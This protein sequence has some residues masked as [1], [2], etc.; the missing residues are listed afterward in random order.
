VSKD[1]KLIRGQVRQIVK[2]ILPAVL[3]DELLQAISKQLVANL[4][5]KLT[6]IEE[7]VKETLQAV[8]QRSKDS[9]SY[10]VRQASEPSLPP[11]AK[12]PIEAGKQ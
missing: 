6:K 4:T 11:S 2:E 1:A 8:D 10:L 7:N 9:L 5:S 12:A 3:K